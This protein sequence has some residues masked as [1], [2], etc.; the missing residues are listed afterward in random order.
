MALT[1]RQKIA[2]GIVL[3]RIALSTYDEPQFIKKIIEKYDLVTGVSYDNDSDCAKELLTLDNSIR[4]NFIGDI[5]NLVCRAPLHHYLKAGLILLKN[6][7]VL[8][9]SY[10]VYNMISK[11]IYDCNFRYG[12][13]VE[14]LYNC[15]KT[16]IKFIDSEGD[17]YELSIEPLNGEIIIKMGWMYTQFY[18]LQNASNWFEHSIFKDLFDSL[19]NDE[20]ELIPT[21]KT[22]T[23]HYHFNNL[24]GVH[25]IICKPILITNHFQ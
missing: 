9:D 6:N 16:I 14:I 2:L 18:F 15:R 21:I 5:I 13:K 4:L 10:I 1:I 7:V 11:I 3:N 17:F 19:S 22:E 8:N 23:F 25:V 12:S 20:K 24:D